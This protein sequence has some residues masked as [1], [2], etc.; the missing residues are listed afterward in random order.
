MTLQRALCEHQHKPSNSVV[1]HV[2]CL[3]TNLV[4]LAR[5]SLCHTDSRYPVT[6]MSLCNAF[7]SELSAIRLQ[8]EPK[9]D[10]Q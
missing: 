9:K 4:L 1:V 3:S 6:T 7:C 5:R 10:S 2:Q 8:F